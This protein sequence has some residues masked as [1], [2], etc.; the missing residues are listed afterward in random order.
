MRKAISRI[1]LGLGLCLLAACGDEAPKDE[2]PSGAIQPELAARGQEVF[3][4]KGC[5]ACHTVGKGRLV[6][7]DLAG[8]TERREY[9]WYVAMVTKPDSMLRHDP[10]AKQLLAEYYTPMTSQN[11]SADDARAIYEFLRRESAS[12]P[13]P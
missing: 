5:V 2:A 11:V 6:G 10:I 9:G 7:P 1:V 12:A 3:Q 4:S 13:A 8:V